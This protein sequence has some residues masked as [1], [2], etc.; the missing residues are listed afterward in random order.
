M[1]TALY[2]RSWESLSNDGAG[3]DRF[4]HLARQ[5]ALSFIDQCYYNDH[6]ARKHVDLLCDIAVGLGSEAAR[7]GG[8]AA[9]FGVLIEQLC[10]DY[11]DFQPE[12]YARVMSQVIARCFDLP[13]GS[14]LRQSLRRFRIESEEDLHRRALHIRKRPNHWPDRNAVDRVYILSR[15]T[16]GADVAIT[17]VLVQRLKRIFPRAEIV[18]LGAAKLGE[19][20]TADCP[21]RIRP[22]QYA[23][24]GNLM[25]RFSSWQDALA[26]LDEENVFRPGPILV[27]DPDSRI[28]QLGMLPLVSDDRYLF[29]DTHDTSAM[30]RKAS[31]AELTNRWVDHVFGSGSP[32][33][34]AVWLPSKSVE[35]AQTLVGKL[36]YEGCKRLIVAN[37]GV[38]GNERKRLGTELEIQ[39]ALSLIQVPGTILL[40]DMGLGTEEQRYSRQ[41]LCSARAMGHVAI[42]VPFSRCPEGNISSGVLC[43]KAT[44]GEIASLIS[45][46]DEFVGYD[47]ACQH[48]AAALGIPTTTIFAGT[49]SPRFIRR[50][51]ASGPALLRIVHVS[52]HTSQLPDHVESIVDRIVRDRSTHLEGQGF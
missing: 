38:G 8:T 44:I 3:E 4:F 42:E 14:Q 13:E 12:T 33:Y 35:A 50:W 22:L 5:I 15:V 6:Y 46:C 26:I 51:K 9:L 19:I 16:I 48:I 10:D 41:I 30:Y 27:I 43:I 29:F 24:S 25:E 23:R 28:S 1:P 34:P 40:L 20:F 49:S 39:L 17:S 21:A 11:E 32:V 45:Q 18:I 37:F 2:Q 7:A 31:M 52:G 47:S 36:R